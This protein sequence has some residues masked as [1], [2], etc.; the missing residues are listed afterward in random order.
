MGVLLGVKWGSGEALPNFLFIDAVKVG[1][2]YCFPSLK[3]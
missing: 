1:G 3:S 2:N